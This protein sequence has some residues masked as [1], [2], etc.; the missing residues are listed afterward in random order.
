MAADKQNIDVDSLDEQIKKLTAASE[1]L[2][3]E[4]DDMHTHA[5]DCEKGVK[6][7]EKQKDQLG[8]M[9]KMKA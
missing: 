1:Q 6:S 2:S 3:G 9:L 7:N 8:K 5:Q 4:L